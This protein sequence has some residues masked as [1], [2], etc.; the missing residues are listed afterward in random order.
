VGPSHLLEIVNGRPGATNI[1]IFNKTGARLLSWSLSTFFGLPVTTEMSDPRAYYDPVAGRW[2]VLGFSVDLDARTDRFYLAISRSTDP[3][4]GFCQYSKDQSVKNGA[5]GV[6]L[7]DFPGMAMDEYALYV[8][9][10]RFSF[11]TNLP[12]DTQVEMFPRAGLSC[13]AS[14]LQPFVWQLTERLPDGQPVWE[15]QPTTTFGS[16]TVAYLVGTSAS[17]SYAGL[18]TITHA[19]SPQLSANSLVV[20]PYAPPSDGQQPNS[21]VLLKLG[22]ARVPSSA[23]FRNG[24]LWFAFTA[25]GT[26][27]PRAAVRWL[28][29]RVPSLT[30]AQ[31]G[32]IWNTD[33]DWS[34]PALM[35]DPTGGMTLLAAFSGPTYAPGAAVLTRAS[36]D[37]PGQT[38]PAATVASGVVAYQA[39]DPRFGTARWGDYFGIALDPDGQHVW[40]EATYAVSA[41]AWSTAIAAVG[42]A[43]ISVSPTPLP[44]P[45]PAPAPV[46]YRVGVSNVAPLAGDSVI[47]TAQAIGPSLLPLAVGGRVVTW[48]ASPSGGVFSTPSS[49]TDS[50]G[51]ATVQFTTSAQGPV[52]YTITARDGTGVSGASPPFT[53]R[54]R[55]AATTV[56][57][58]NI[59]KTLGGPAGWV[60]PFYVQNSG[61]VQT[62]LEISF[63]RFSDGVLMAKR[64]VTGL[65]PGTSF[66]DNPNNDGDLPGFTQ[67]S[68]VIQSFGAPIVAVANETQGVGATTQSSSYAGVSQGATRIFLPNVTRRFFGYDVPIILQN[69]GQSQ[70]IATASFVSFDGTQRF[71]TSLPIASGRSAVID[72]D[73]TLGLVDGTQYA[74]TITS[75]QP[76]TAVANAHNEQGAPVAF[77]H[78][79]L[80]VGS[81]TLYAPYFANQSL[82]TG[83]VSPAVVQNL[84]IS[85]VDA[86]LRFTPLG[87]GGPV[88]SLVLAG[89]APGAARAF[90]PRFTLG[91]TTPCTGPSPTCLGPGEFSLQITASGPIA[92]VVL[93]TTP[94]T[95][96][97]YAAAS[98]AMAHAY[99]PFV[100]LNAAPPTGVTGFVVVQSV[101]A[102]SASLRYYR[103][104]D[105]TLAV[106][107]GLSLAA[108]TSV[109]I[110]PRNAPGLVD[111][112]YAVVID[113]NGTLA[114]IVYELAPLGD[115]A[116]IYEGFAVQ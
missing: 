40:V 22:D 18:W 8:T 93:P 60:T 54:Q 56:Y 110:D 33:S 88:Q 21:T 39:V 9:T 51:A 74:V 75:D 10:T 34:Y 84:G 80:A 82:A 36:T 25:R 58:P 48:T 77:S 14:N 111:G 104:S 44:S 37:P 94:T 66:V 78:N 108:G 31:Q 46:S 115:G 101:T 16:S 3:T 28:E 67:F 109:W 20:G 41:N 59:T 70:A 105:G 86:T 6:V 35:I 30:V 98:V 81:S 23:V 12:V 107:Q 62:D 112:S 69:L 91:T 72:P 116:M 83:R 42:A 57:L 102:T 19:L 79:G 97:A 113:G 96:A 43:Q 5:S 55:V 1:A 85:V 38:G 65:A 76:L 89:I 49:T 73:F 29:I 7:A 63:Y 24:S 27:T 52:T 99:L 2:Y 114:A 100:G 71:T 15:V 103:I 11:S 53:T 61:T 92:A 106:T 95:A 4:Q 87:V 13:D 64:S 50:N 90:D 32:E 17:G 45:T 68:V 47:V 26:R